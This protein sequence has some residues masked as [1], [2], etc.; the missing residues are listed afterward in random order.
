MCVYC[1]DLN[2]DQIIFHCI[3]HQKNSYFQGFHTLFLATVCLCVPLLYI[4][5]L[6]PGSVTREKGSREIKEV[7]IISTYINELDFLGTIIIITQTLIFV[8]Y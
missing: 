6:L 5:F 2:E 1:C 4:S 3:L 7:W 8:K